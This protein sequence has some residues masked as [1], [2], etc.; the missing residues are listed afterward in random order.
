ML[1][2]EIINNMKNIVDNCMGDS[3]EACQTSCPMNTDVKQYIKLIR[4][5]KGKESLKVIREKLFIPRILGRICAHPCESGCRRGEEDKPLAISNLKRY[6]ADNFDKPE[7]WDL[8]KLEFNGKKVAIIGAGPAGTQAAYSLIKKGYSVTIFEKENHLGGMMRF[9]IPE[10]RLPSK[11]IDSELSILEKLGVNINLGVQIG[12]DISIDK[13]KS[14]FHAVIVAIGK[15]IGRVDNSL[16]NID[17]KGIFTAAEFLREVSLTENFKDIGTYTLTVGGGDV[18]MDCARSAI[19]LKKVKHSYLIALEKD[20]NSL[21]ASKHEVE[22][23]LKEG[24]IF[25][26]SSGI[27]HIEKDS[28]GRINSITSKKCLAMFDDKGNFNPQ[29]DEIIEE[30]IS[31]DTLIFAI[32]QNIDFSI[33]K[34]E[35]LKK[36]GDRGFSFDNLTLQ[37]KYVDNIFFAGDCSNS[38]IVIQAMATG[39]RAAKTVDRFLNNLNLKEGRKIE[40]EG[41][42]ST[43]KLHMPTDYLPTGWDSS[44]KVMRNNSLE[45]SME[46]RKKNFKE[47]EFSFT[48]EQAL[49]ESNRCLECECKLCMK[50]CLM[51]PKF[52]SCP[53]TLFQQYLEIGYENMD[54]N[55]AYSCNECSQCTIKCPNDFK[56]EDNFKEMRKEYVRANDGLS[57]F[58]DHTTLDDGQELECSK[59]YSIT[60]PEKSKKT[61]Y[62]LIP[63]CTVPASMPKAVEDTLRHMK[64][65]LG[66]ENVAV[67][68]QCCAKPTEIIGESDLFNERYS[69]VQN[70]IEKLNADV[71][72]TLC[73][74]C[75]NT[76][77]KYSGKKVI[78]YWDLMK[79][80]IGIPVKQK[81][82]GSA[83]DVIFNIHDSCPTRNMTSHH[84]SVR[85]ILKE[86]GYKIEEMKNIRENT[87]CCGVGGMLGCINA[88]LYKEIVDRRVSDATQKHII[89]YCGSCRG[90]MELGG[91]DSLHILQLIHEGCYMKKDAM[92]RSENYGFHNRLE[93]K[94]RLKKFL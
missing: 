59:K 5:G 52:T 89:S 23:A 75:F 76:Y 72:V 48:K 68:L 66:D 31:I 34:N 10:Y 58:S 51:L 8:S 35:L 18:A 15:Q 36:S 6:V 78:S 44:E 80:E 7:N 40:D 45:L 12:K 93:T 16:K 43:T 11:V 86:L 83:S 13:L 32:G 3:I 74:S 62:V 37:S 47:V 38:L 26:L 60:I 69:R 39:Q 57:P 73:P 63:G 91:L 1:K 41:G 28:T 2:N 56:I 55:I 17:A 22:S 82:I 84:D 49:H 46:E 24:V 92:K 94:K 90:S 53:K 71:I 29:F 79:E 70:E 50:E 33:D 14:D 4:E 21:T 87:R 64:E 67:I 81:E 19:R 85:W 25:I 88:N 42:K 61:K 77:K 30:K 27:K 9:G 65:T 54:K 20:I